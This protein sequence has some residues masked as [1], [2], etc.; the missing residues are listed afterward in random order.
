MRAGTRPGT[1]SRRIASAKQAVRFLGVGVD[2]GGQAE[3]RL[4]RLFGHPDPV[5]VPA[6][7]GKVLG[8]DGIGHEQ[9]PPWWGEGRV[10]RGETPRAWEM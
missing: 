6:D 5:A 2:L 7:L 4:N 1:A 9:L 8:G 10:A 3:T